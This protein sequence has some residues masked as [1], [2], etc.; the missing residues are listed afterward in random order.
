MA[1]RVARDVVVYSGLATVKDEMKVNK[2]A[3]VHYMRS[4]ATSHIE[5]NA[6]LRVN[7]MEIKSEVLQLAAAP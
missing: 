4:P 5:F 6:V 1:R 2:P 3:Q 7:T